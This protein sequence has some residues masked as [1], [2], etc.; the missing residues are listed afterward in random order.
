MVRLGN[1]LSTSKDAVG[2]FYYAGHAVQSNG[3][4]YLVPADAHIASE[5][6]LRTKALAAEEVLDILHQAHNALNVM[7]LDACRDNPFSWARSGTRGLTV[8]SAQPPGSIIAYAT[9]AGSVAQDGTGRNGVFTA[10]LLKNLSTPGIEIKEVFNRTG[11][12]VER[13]QPSEHRSRDIVQFFG[14]AFLAGRAPS[15][16]HD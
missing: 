9:S 13:R 11:S 15:Q 10:E 5:S 16:C 12:A 1:Q 14:S 8:M 3:I 2:F 7:V 4:N 6:F